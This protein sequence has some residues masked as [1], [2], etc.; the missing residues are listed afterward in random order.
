MTTNQSSARPTAYLAL[1]LILAL[2]VWLRITGIGFGLPYLYHPDEPSKVAAAENIVRTGDLNPHYFAKPTLLIYANALLYAAYLEWGKATGRLTS[3]A[4]LAP[5]EQL[6]MGVGR[7]ATPDVMVLG[8]LLSVAVGA[9]VVLL[10]YSVGK[11][12]LRDWVAALFAALIVAVSFQQVVQS[13]YI[14]VNVFLTA[15][16][17]GVAWASLRLYER[18]GRTSYLLAGFLVGIAITSKYPGVVGIVFPAVAHWLRSGRTLVLTREAKL[19]LL[20]IPVGFF[21][22]T[23]YAL[24]DPFNFVTGAGY[25]AYHYST[26]HEGLEGG[27]PF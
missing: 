25:E 9:L 23:P 13:H 14:E 10:T 6:V 21:L 27:A 19:G 3:G 17:L 5:P 12:F 18:G 24:L 16:L 8:R 11:R 1:S 4:D 15:A 22:G 26:G 20:M 7:I 2:A